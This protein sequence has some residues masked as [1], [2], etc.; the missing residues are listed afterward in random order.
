MFCIEWHGGENSSFTLSGGITASFDNK[1]IKSLGSGAAT[2]TVT[3]VAATDLDQA[4]KDLVGDN[5]VFEISFGNNT[6]FGEGKATFTVPYVLPEGK[7]ASD[8]KVYFIKD[9]KVAE[10]I[11]CTYAD[12]K[13]T[14]STGHLSTYSV[15]FIDTGNGGGTE[16]PIWIVAAIAVVAIAGVGGAVF[17]KKRKA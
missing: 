2:L 3:K 15:G 5:P 7:S 13:A 8:L 6:N 9:G 1:A 17:L 11:D 12:G 10:T 4:V 16:F 14:F